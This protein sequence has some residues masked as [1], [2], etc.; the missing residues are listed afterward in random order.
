VAVSFIRWWKT[1]YLEKTTELSEVN[2]KL[3]CIMLFRVHLVFLKV[4]FFK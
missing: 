4:R 3:Y 2:N 1:E